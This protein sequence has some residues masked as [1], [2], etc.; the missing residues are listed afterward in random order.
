MQE[1]SMRRL[2]T[3][4]AVL[5]LLAFAVWVFF[6]PHLTLRSMQSAAEAGDV[7][8][9]SRHV[10]YPALR[11]SVKQQLSKELGAQI[12]TI[13]GGSALGRFGAKIAGVLGNNGLDQAVDVMVRPEALSALFAGRD[14]ANQYDLLPSGGGQTDA[15]API[16]DTSKPPA[17]ETAPSFNTSDLR[18]HIGYESWDRFAVNVQEPNTGRQVKLILTRDKL[19]W[20]K[21][22]AVELGPR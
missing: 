19:L 6:A 1:L 8:A 4:L 10:D 14:L 9:L 13:A 5:I 12:A 21:L 17:S 22:S 2:L 11:E 16:A 3:P 15:Q 18:T 20:W 7:E